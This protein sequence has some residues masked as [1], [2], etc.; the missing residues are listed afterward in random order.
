MLAHFAAMIHD[1][2]LFSKYVIFLLNGVIILLI[3]G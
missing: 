2:F 3:K 1:I